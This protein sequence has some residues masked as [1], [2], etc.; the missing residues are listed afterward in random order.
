M[1]ISVWSVCLLVKLALRFLF[2]IVA[3]LILI[4]TME[5]VFLCVLLALFPTQPHWLA[6]IVNHLV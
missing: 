3:M 5:P 6:K 2:V 4:C 1:E